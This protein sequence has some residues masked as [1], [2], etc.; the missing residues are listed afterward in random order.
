[1]QSTFCSFSRCNDA[2]SRGYAVRARLRKGI[3]RTERCLAGSRAARSDTREGRSNVGNKAGWTAAAA[4]AGAAWI[5]E[6][7][8]VIGTLG[9]VDLPHGTILVDDQLFRVSDAKLVGAAVEE[10]KE[11]DRVRVLY[12]E[13]GPASSDPIDAVQIDRIEE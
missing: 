3:S 5:A 7:T 13:G 1:M 4:T 11:G 10:L 9:K 12:A 2:G 6:D 8:E